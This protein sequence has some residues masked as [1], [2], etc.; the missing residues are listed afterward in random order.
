MAKRT[1]KDIEKPDFGTYH[2]STPAASERLRERT[3][4]QFTEAF[5]SLPF[6]RDDP[7]RILDIGCGLGFLSCVSAK[8]YPKAMVTGVDT[9]EDPSLRDSS[10]AKARENAEM[11][12]LSRRVKFERGDI[13]TSDYYGRRFDL[14]VSNLVYHNLGK[15]RYDAY[16]RLAKWASPSSYVVIGDIYFDYRT[17]SKRLGALFGSFETRPRSKRD[18][19]YRILLL[20][21]PK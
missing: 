11:M 7:L 16:K 5:A 21:S 1:G 3:R 17:D 14:L 2:H 9:F 8:Y 18:G 10:L 12:G 4:V 6:T 20:S 13:L 19:E 15:K